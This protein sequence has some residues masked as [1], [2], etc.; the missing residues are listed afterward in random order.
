MCGDSCV[1]YSFLGSLFGYLVQ[2]FYEIAKNYGVAIILFTI[3]TRL[4]MFPLTIKQQKTTAAQQRLQPKLNELKQKFGN[5]KQGY[6]EAVQALYQK[7][8]VSMSGGCLPMLIQFPLFFGMYAAIRQPLSN[9]LHLANDAVQNACKILSIDTSKYYY[10]IDLINKFREFKEK[11]DFLVDKVQQVAVRAEQGDLLSGLNNLM[12]DSLNTLLNRD[13]VMHSKMMQTDITGEVVEALGQTGFDKAME[14][15]DKFSFFGIDLLETA[16]FS[17]ANLALILA[18]VT[19]IC[20]IGGMIISNRM[21][22][23]SS[24][25]AQ[26]CNPNVMSVVF[27]GMSFFFALST[28]AAFPLY[29][30]ASSLLGPVQ[31]WVTRE[32]FGPVMMNAK[33][34]AQRN[35]RLK[36]DEQKRIKE[37]NDAKGTLRLEPCMPT[38]AI[39]ETEK[40][41]RNNN[42]SN[43]KGNKNQKNRNK[44]GNNNGGYVGKKK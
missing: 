25:G 34:E 22:K 9:V 3:A 13:A 11:G 5:D 17:P 10:E 1:V 15:S 43:A 37:A 12:G 14:M 41:G 20:Q 33:A 36:L 27:G 23:V 31:T 6:N 4:F 35:T 8:G 39:E 26:G 19:V 2:L 40:S 32:Y 24:A 29:W 30:T 38:V 28:P 18:F 42:K 7:E 21:N 44:G 16:S